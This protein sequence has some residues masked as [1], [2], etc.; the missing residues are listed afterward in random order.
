MLGQRTSPL[1]AKVGS[2]CLQTKRVNEVWSECMGEWSMYRTDPGGR[3]IAR[4]GCIPVMVPWR[5]HESIEKRVM[6]RLRRMVVHGLLNGYSTIDYI[7]PP[8][9]IRTPFSRCPTF[10]FTIILSSSTTLIPPISAIFPSLSSCGYQ[11]GHV[12]LPCPPH[13]VAHHH[14]SS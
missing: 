9:D 12:A 6:I 3:G 2:C 5:V 10:F 13:G 14:Q 11:N 8:P 4:S 7:S 1:T